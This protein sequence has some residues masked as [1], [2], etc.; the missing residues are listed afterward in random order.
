MKQIYLFIVFLLKKN[1]LKH[2]FTIICFLSV[3]FLLPDVSYSQIDTIATADTSNVADTSGFESFFSEQELTKYLE[4]K[5]LLWVGI[6]SLTFYG[7]VRD[8]YYTN[9]LVGRRPFIAGISR[10]LTPFLT[11][12]FFI[13][14]GNMSGN[15]QN[16]GRNL[17]FMTN[18]FIGGA[19]ISYNF[20]HL[21][22]K[23]DIFL[24]LEE[25][26]I[27]IPYLSIGIETM[28][29]NSK[30]DM[31]DGNG[32]LYHYWSD[33]T[34]RDVEETPENE[35]ISVI[36]HRDYIYETDLRELN[37][38]GLGKYDLST[39]GIPIGLGFDFHMT[40]R[41]S[42][43]FGTT[44]HLMFNDLIDNVSPAGTGNRK[45]NKQND[46]FLYTY[47]GIKMD[48]FSSEKIID[49]GILDLI[50]F[51]FSKLD[52]S[53]EDGDGV[54]DLWD[55]CPNTPPEVSVDKKGCPLDEDKDGIPDFR[56]D[57]L[58]SADTAIVG[59]NGV[60]LTDEQ[61]SYLSDTLPA[62]DMN[63]ICDY[64]PSMCGLK[65]LKKRHFV[66]MPAKYIDVDTNNDGYISLD[67]LNNVLDK[68]FDLKTDLSIDDIYELT[69]FFFKQ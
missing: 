20:Y 14:K 48:I 22:K 33:G 41:I 54:I 61:I 10:K 45:G 65:N 36:L 52:K 1:R 32:N 56:D 44:Y 17:N 7:D 8:S 15:E 38:D 49:L 40:K 43:R 57:E 5:P 13:M 18:F 30:T 26:R 68:F 11:G 12:D 37:L 39:L 16:N 53:D 50:K 60:T 46:S 6:G 31:K 62:V 21:L 63:K 67:E 4:Y 3:M 9:P 34:I 23:P 27:L 64:Y 35:M 24:P 29:F 59:T 55:E 2:Y 51:D 25:Q 19:S 47:V 42:L 69:D 28:N 58:A 66:E